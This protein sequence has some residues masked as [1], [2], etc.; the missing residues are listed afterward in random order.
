MSSSFNQWYLLSNL[1]LS[2]LP[3]HGDFPACYAMREAETGQILKFG[4]TGNFRKRIVGNYMAGF[5]GQTTQRIHGELFSKGMI[6]KIEISWI[7]TKD[8]A[9]S[10][11]ME[12]Q[13]RKAHKELHGIRPVWDLID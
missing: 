1:A 3:K 2:H 5:G 4:C 13:F 12:S 6:S 9:E 11:T 10:K 8:A 7:E